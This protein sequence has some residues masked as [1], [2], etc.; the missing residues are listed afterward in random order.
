LRSIARADQALRAWSRG[1]GGRFAI[2]SWHASPLCWAK[3]EA[4]LQKTWSRGTE[5]RTALERQIESAAGIVFVLRE[6]QK[7]G[8]AWFTRHRHVHTYPELRMTRAKILGGASIG[9]RAAGRRG[10]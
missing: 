1:F 2:R 5:F 6:E 3:F 9:V 4:V 7:S 8:G 10:S